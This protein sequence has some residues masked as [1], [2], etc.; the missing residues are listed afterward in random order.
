MRGLTRAS[1]HKDAADKGA[2][3]E[4]AAGKDALHEDAPHQYAPRGVDPHRLVLHRTAAHRIGPR[5]AALIT[6]GAVVGFA[7]VGGLVLAGCGT[8]SQGLRKEGPARTSW[9]PEQADS[10]GSYVHGTSPTSTSAKQKVDAVALLKKDPKVSEHLKTNLKPCSKSST[11]DTQSDATQSDATQ[12]D[13]AQDAPQDATKDAPQSA[14]QEAKKGSA[15]SQGYPIDVAYGR[16]TGSTAADL[17][18]N[19]MTCTEGF[20]LGS[21]VYRKVG[22]TYENV[23]ADERPPVYADT[24]KGN[25]RVTKLVYASNDSV[26]CPSSEDVTTYRWA[27]K[28]REFLVTDRKTRN[29]SEDE[30]PAPDDGTEG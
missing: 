15:K 17:V 25:L 19:V 29:V 21:Y 2:S 28:R 4:D 12:N 10:P 8:G 5:R 30:S 3:N 24:T 18:V 23:F 6:G 20:G 27:E 16:L 1:P 11:K 26:C 9:A 13:A 7:A 14:P 22:G